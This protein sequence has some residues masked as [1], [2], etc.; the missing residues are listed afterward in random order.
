MNEQDKQAIYDAI[1]QE[2]QADDKYPHEVIRDQYGGNEDEYLAD[3][4]K[5]MPKKE[6]NGWRY[7]EKIGKS[8]PL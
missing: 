7:K 2:M 4:I 8:A 5:S 1:F 3:M 6:D